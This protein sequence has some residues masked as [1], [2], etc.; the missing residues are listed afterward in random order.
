MRNARRRVFVRFGFAGPSAVRASSRSPAAAPGEPRVPSYG[1]E[2]LPR[3]LPVGKLHAGREAVEVGT[4][5]PVDR[6]VTAACAIVRSA[7]EP[8]TVRG[9]AEQLAAAER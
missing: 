5:D 6:N 7:T 2:P 8:G 4:N 3:L 9:L 1:S